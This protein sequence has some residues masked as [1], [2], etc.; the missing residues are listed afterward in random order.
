[1][2]FGYQKLPLVCP[3]ASSTLGSK[4]TYAVPGRSEK[5]PLLYV[6][7]RLSAR[8]A[9]LGHPA[10]RRYAVLLCRLASLSPPNLRIS[11][12]QRQQNKG[13]RSPVLPRKRSRKPMP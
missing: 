9:S 3:V 2:R 4:P 7:F 11:R 13:F 5:R 8:S 10:R 1:M 12:E 6:R